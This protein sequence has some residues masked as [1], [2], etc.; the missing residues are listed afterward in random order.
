MDNAPTTGW[1]RRPSKDTRCRDLTRDALSEM[2]HQTTQPAA[3][4]S[5]VVPAPAPPVIA[6]AGELTLEE[7]TDADSLDGRP[8]G[9]DPHPRAGAGGADPHPQGPAA[10]GPAA[11]TRARNA[12]RG[13]RALVRP[14]PVRCARCGRRG[15]VVRHTTLARHR[16]RPHPHAPRHDRSRHRPAPPAPQRRGPRRPRRLR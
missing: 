9:T 5:I 7:A 3:A 1:A 10:R 4:S 2:T 8:T 14:A 11:P 15:R 16:G 6:I 13:P 12:R